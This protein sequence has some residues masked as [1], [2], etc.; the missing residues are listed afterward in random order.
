MLGRTSAKFLH[1]RLDART[2][3]AAH[4]DEKEVADGGEGERGKEGV[5]GGT[6]EFCFRICFG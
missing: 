1:V 2:D 6:Y 3:G 4:P 5:G